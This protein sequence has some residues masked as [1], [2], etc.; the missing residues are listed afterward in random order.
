MIHIDFDPDKL[1]TPLK[2]EWEALQKEVQ[3]ATEAL[4][5]KWE[6]TR[7]LTQ[8]DLK[9]KIW[10]NVNTWLKD[11]VFYGK[12]AYCETHLER[13][14]QTGDAEHY[15]PKLKV[16]YKAPAKKSYVTPEA[17]QELGQMVNHPGYFWLAYHWK[18]LLPSC[19]FC[20]AVDGKKN[21]FPTAKSH[22]LARR[23][24]PDEVARLREKPFE[25]PTQAGAYY[26][27]PDDLDAIED[28]ILLHPYN[29]RPENHLV[30][31]EF[32]DVVARTNTGQNSAK[33]EQSIEVYNL[34]G[35]GLKISRQSAQQQAKMKFDVAQ[36]Y[37]VLLQHL[38]TAEARQRVAQEGDI[39]EILFGRSP[40]SAAQ[41]AYLKLNHCLD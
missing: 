14:R 7:K 10:R 23:L 12:C 5:H 9:D 2:G 37:F 38:S 34:N 3:E 19:K 26:L 1:S 13:A 15:R 11:H 39:K 41:V 22:V 16:N 21:Q 35:S 6:T 36:N 4:I 18:N 30:F 29:D 17:E 40:Y 32:G 8:D 28:P 27:K 31:G 25:S 33:G 24:T 20:N